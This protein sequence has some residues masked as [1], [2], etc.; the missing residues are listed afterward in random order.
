M[1][2]VPGRLTCWEFYRT[3][4]NS[5]FPLN[6]SFSIWFEKNAPARADCHHIR[7]GPGVDKH[8]RS[9]TSKAS[10]INIQKQEQEK[11][12]FATATATKHTADWLTS[13]EVAGNLLHNLLQASIFG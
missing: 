1:D 10:S 3:L 9:L 8:Q 12:T 6:E 11:C 4:P 7:N 2:S 5:A 13:A